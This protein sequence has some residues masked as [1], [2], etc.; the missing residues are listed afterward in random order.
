MRSEPR[1]V[2]RDDGWNSLIDCW[3]ASTSTLEDDEF[4][5]YDLISVCSHSGG[6]GG[7]HY[8]AHTKSVEDGL[9]YLMNDSAVSRSQALGH[10]SSAYV[11]FY[12]RSGGPT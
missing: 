12:R 1:S 10:E 4:Q 6:L 2:R 3:I 11:L 8:V 7:G 9:W 5:P